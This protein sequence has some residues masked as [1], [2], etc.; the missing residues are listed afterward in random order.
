[1]ITQDELVQR[2]RDLQVALAKRALSP[3]ELEDALN[4][5]KAIQEIVSPPVE[6]SRNITELKGLGKEFWRSIDV[7]EYIREERRSWRQP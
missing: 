5:V 3:R 2:L 1:V 7:D 6:P 4:Q